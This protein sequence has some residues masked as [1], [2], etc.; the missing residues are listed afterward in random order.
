MQVKKKSQVEPMNSQNTAQYY[1]NI[2]K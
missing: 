1:A 2:Y